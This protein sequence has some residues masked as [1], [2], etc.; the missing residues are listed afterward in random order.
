MGVMKYGYARVS[1]DNQT[2]ALCKLLKMKVYA[3]LG[4]L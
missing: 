4:R 1:T 2:P 3:Q